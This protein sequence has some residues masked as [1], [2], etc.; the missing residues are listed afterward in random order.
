[1]DAPS[2]T[3][4]APDDLAIVRSVLAGDGHAREQDRGD[5]AVGEGS[6][7]EAVMLAAT[8]KLSNL[9]AIVDYNKSLSN[10]SRHK[11]T[12]MDRYS[13]ELQ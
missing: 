13:L 1:M 10:L 11:A 9:T 5:I 3:A 8:L 12:T 4:V 6:V 2:G 7:W